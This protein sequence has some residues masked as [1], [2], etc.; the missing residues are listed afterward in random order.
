LSIEESASAGSKLDVDLSAKPITKAELDALF[1]P[2]DLKRLDSYANNM[3]DYHVI[4]D[5]LPSIALLYFSGRLKST[6]TLSGVQ[7]ALLLAIGLQRKEFSD[8]E[9]E[10]NLNASQLMAMFVKVVRKA[11]TAF[12]NIVEGAVE[13]TMPEAMEVE[14]QGLDG[15]ATDGADHRFKPLTKDLQEELEEGG[16]EVL[17]EER[18][19]ARGLIDAL[20]LHK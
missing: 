5:M 16:D 7:R 15:D 12:R 14:E 2:F 3:L 9:K 8:V 11:A 4:L 6:V 13:E 17:R 20:P 10:L 18:E 19:R 1:T